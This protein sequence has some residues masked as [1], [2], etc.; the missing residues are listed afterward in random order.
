MSRPRRSAHFVPAGNEKMLRKALGFEADSLI[1][2]LEDSVT[3]ANKGTVRDTVTAWLRDIDFGRQERIVRINAIDSPWGWDDLESVLEFAPDA[4]LVPKARAAIELGE[5][6]TKL[7]ALE[8][9]LGID[10]GSTRL[11]VLAGET[12]QGVLAIRELAAASRVDSLTWGPEDLS[13]EI[14]AR[15]NRNEDGEFL[16]VFRY[17]RAMTLLAAAAAGIQPLDS[18]FVDIRDSEGLR[19]ECAEVAAMG[20]TGKLTLHPDQIPIVNEAFTPSATEI[21][22]AREL[23]EAFVANEQAGKGVFTFN[24][25]MVDAPHLKRARRM[26]ELAEALN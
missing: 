14:G 25:Q 24:G 26:V 23:L 15:S 12:P 7:D 6:A 3:A 2:D 1:L 21:A 13:A 5:I 4:I 22:E 20:F 8:K 17:A 11:I 9:K 10:K 19:R 16:E 18:V